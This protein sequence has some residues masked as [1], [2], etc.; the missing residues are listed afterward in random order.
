MDCP[1]RGRHTDGVSPGQA[2]VWNVG[3]CPSMRRENSKWQPHE[4]ERTDA[5][6]GTDRPVVARNPVNAGGAKGPASPA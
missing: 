2:C 1:S 3:T 6:G 5:R 4:E